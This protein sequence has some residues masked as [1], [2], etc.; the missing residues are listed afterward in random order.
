MKDEIKKKLEYLRIR[1]FTE[2]W[3]HYLE[4]AEQKKLSHQKLLEYIVSDLFG[5]KKSHAKH[6]RLSRARIPEKYVIET[7][8]FSRQ[9]RLNKKKIMNIYDSLDYMLKRR[10]LVLVGQTGC[11]KTGLGTAFLMHAIEEGFSGHFV[12]FPELLSRFR[13]AE[14]DHSEDKILKKFVSFDCLLIDELGYVEVKP[15]Q[16][17]LF[18]RLMHARHKRKSTIVTSN[19]GFSQWGSFLKNDHLTAALIDRLTENSYII[20]MRG[21]KTLRPKMKT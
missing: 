18:F 14:A 10:N 20:N 17:G 13:R 12:E 8:P 1:G 11:G 4:I 15:A 9:P 7:Y 2:R 3:E 16:V 5:A 6:L 21:C 19:L